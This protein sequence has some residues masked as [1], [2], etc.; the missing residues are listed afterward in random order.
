MNC[1]FG[2]SATDSF[3]FAR[4]APLTDGLDLLPGSCCPHYG[5]EPQRRLTL[6]RAAGLHGCDAEPAIAQCHLAKGT[7]GTP[8]G[9]DADRDTSWPLF[10]VMITVLFPV[11]VTFPR[12]SRKKYRDL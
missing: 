12:Y 1:W 4:L 10:T 3:G 5:G 2:Q 11:A 6:P 7:Q 8:G 9:R